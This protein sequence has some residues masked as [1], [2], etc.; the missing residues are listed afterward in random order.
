MGLR[1]LGSKFLTLPKKIKNKITLDTFLT[2]RDRDTLGWYPNLVLPF[3][4]TQ[5]LK[6]LWVGGVFSDNREGKFPFLF[7][8]LILD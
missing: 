8:D 2:L 1:N 5:T 6:K 7:L 4:P 3:R